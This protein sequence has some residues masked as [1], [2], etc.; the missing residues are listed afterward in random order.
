MTVVTA[1]TRGVLVVAGTPIGDIGDASSRLAHALA[2][3][4]VIA[5]EDTRRFGRLR[6]ALSV[7][8]SARVVSYFE[9]NEDRRTDELLGALRNG[10]RVVL[11]T[12]AGMP[13]ISDPGYRLVAAAIEAG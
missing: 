5:A 13:G 10:A 1:S 3:A 4:D 6:A 8:T 2:G 11:L 12:D 9:A 7:E